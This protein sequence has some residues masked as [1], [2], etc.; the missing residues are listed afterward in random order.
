VPGPAQ[1]HVSFARLFVAASLLAASASVLAQ[2]D[3]SVLPVNAHSSRYGSGLASAVR[4]LSPG[5]LTSSKSFGNRTLSGVKGKRVCDA[6]RRGYSNPPHTHAIEPRV[7][8]CSLRRAVSPA[9]LFLTNDDL[10]R[11]CVAG[12][13]A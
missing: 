3:V 13:R 2:T 7:V 1:W 4:V 6:D 10:S 12:V 9:R 8:Q 11:L 5:L